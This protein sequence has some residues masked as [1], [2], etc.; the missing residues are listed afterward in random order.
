M[1]IGGGFRIPDI[2]ETSGAKLVEVGAT[3]KTN[4]NDYAKAITPNTAMILKVH[5]SNFYIG[6]FTDEP[7]VTEIADL[8]HEHNLPLVEDIGSGAMMATDDLA[9]IDHEPTPQE[10]LRNGIDLVCFS[11][12]KLLGGPQSGI[13]AGRQD[14]VDGIKKEPFFRAV[15]CDKLILATL[16]ECLDTYL[17][18]QSNKHVA[19]VP[20]LNFISEPI[21][22]LHQRA[23]EL[24]ASLDPDIQQICSITKTTSRTGGG[25]MPKSEIPSIAI[26]IKP[27]NISLNKLARMLRIGTPAIVGV[28]ENEQIHLDLRTVFSHQDTDIKKALSELLST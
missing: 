8:A 25:T 4:L 19:D 11:G 18:T 2:L 3:N 9:P 20:V 10:A 1:E 26:S 23:Q 17:A 21:D 6:G 27:Q 13:I 24:I 7:E 5:R 16:Q 14:L 28:T 12:D 15:R 22:T